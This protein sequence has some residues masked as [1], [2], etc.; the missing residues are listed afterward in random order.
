MP[1]RENEGS[2]EHFE[3]WKQRRETG[4]ESPREMYRQIS[5]IAQFM[6]HDLLDKIQYLE[7]ETLKLPEEEIDE[8]IPHIT[9]FLEQ[10]K[11]AY[12]MFSD[13]DL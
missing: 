9:A 7:K 1:D 3:D 5:H 2:A 8:R 6:S 13:V 10:L 4:D 12:E 11:L